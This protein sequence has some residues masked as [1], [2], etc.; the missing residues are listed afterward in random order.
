D[1]PISAAMLLSGDNLLFTPAN[2]APPW[3]A[4]QPTM[5]PPPYVLSV[6][7]GPASGERFDLGYGVNVLGRTGDCTL[8]VPD[9]EVSRRH[10][11]LPVVPEGV[12]LEGLG[13]S[14]GTVVDGYRLTQAVP[15]LPG[16]VVTA[17]ATIFTVEPQQVELR[18]AQVVPRDG[19]LGLN[20]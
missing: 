16:Q 3:G 2:T 13:S 19:A 4:R 20:R 6:V 17:G 5:L 8:V 15:P 11:S 12:I 10:L 18:M 9:P 14:A 7:G 1:H